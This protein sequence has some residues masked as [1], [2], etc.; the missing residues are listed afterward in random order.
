MQI[1]GKAVAVYDYKITMRRT[2]GLGW[3]EAPA[4]SEEEEEEEGEQEAG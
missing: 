1:G 2:A 3:R 4:L